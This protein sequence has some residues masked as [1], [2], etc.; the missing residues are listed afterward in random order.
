MH[1]YFDWFILE[2]E[3]KKSIV[4][5]ETKLYGFLIMEYT[6]HNNDINQHKPFTLKHVLTGLAQFCRFNTFA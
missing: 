4:F 3:S 5:R 1:L 6:I 2:Y